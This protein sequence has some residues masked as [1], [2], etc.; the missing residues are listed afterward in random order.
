MKYKKV[1]ELEVLYA[2][3]NI[4][5]IGGYWIPKQLV[6]QHLN[7]SVYQVNKHCKNLIEQGLLKRWLAEPFHDIEYESGIDY[8]NSLKVWITE[9]TDKGIDKLKELNLYHER[10]Y[11]DLLK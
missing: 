9:I 1:S 4:E 3:G 6:A 10:W 5:I 8:G 11:E 7:T 2:F